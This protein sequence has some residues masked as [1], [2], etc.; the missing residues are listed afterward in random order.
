MLLTLI[1]TRFRDPAEKLD[2][3]GRTVEEQITSFVYDVLS[4]AGFLVLSF[5]KVPY[6]CEGDLYEDFFVLDDYVFVLK[7]KPE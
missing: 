5:T 2:I 1:G 6:L 4:P 3:H 7:L